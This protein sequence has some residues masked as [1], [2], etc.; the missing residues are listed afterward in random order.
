MEL[1]GKIAEYK[2]QE[3]HDVFI[4]AFHSRGA[5]FAVADSEYKYCCELVSR[6]AYYLA[7]KSGKLPVYID[8]C[9]WGDTVES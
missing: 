8:E 6:L 7:E 4:L 3:R 9:L 2:V 5:A 1:L